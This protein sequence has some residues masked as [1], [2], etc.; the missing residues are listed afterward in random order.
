MTNHYQFPLVRA[1]VNK[2]A[3]KEIAHFSVH[4]ALDSGRIIEAAELIAKLQ[5]MIDEIRDNQDF[6]DGVRDEIAKYG[7]NVTTSSGTKL[8]LSEHGKP[9]YN[10]CGD[11]ILGQLEQ[12]AKSASAALKERQEFLKKL[13]ASGLD[14]ITPEGEV[15]HIYP[16]G[17]ISTSSYKVT[18]AK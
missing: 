6:I 12:A 9:D 13:P 4:E 5:L 14:I 11:P 3:I 1:D 16:P 7:K 8:E 15:V 10:T 17:K 2:T 18:I